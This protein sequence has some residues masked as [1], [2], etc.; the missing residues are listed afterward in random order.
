[1]R[2]LLLIVLGTAALGTGCGPAGAPLVGGGS[3]TVALTVEPVARWRELRLEG[4][5]DLPDGAVVTYHV[6][7]AVATELP[8]DEWPAGNLMTDGTAVVQ[9]GRFW[10]ALNT[11]YWPAGAVQVRVQFPV[12]P[13]PETVRTRY[14]DFG[15][16]LTGDNVVALGGSNVVTAEQTIEWTR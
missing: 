3:E 13:Q 15:E 7:H 8:P 6:T 1:M 12:A 11:T 10:A 9:E 2:G 5:T 4:T 14:G 16:Q